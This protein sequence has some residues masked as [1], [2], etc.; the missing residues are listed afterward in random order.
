MKNLKTG[1]MHRALGYA[2]SILVTMFAALLGRHLVSA[3]PAELHPWLESAVPVSIPLQ[4]VD[5]LMDEEQNTFPSEADGASIAE[6]QMD[7]NGARESRGMHATLQVHILLAN[8]KGASD[9]LVLFKLPR[10]CYADIDELSQ[11]HRGFNW[12]R[13]D[14]HAA[15]T[16][17]NPELLAEQAPAEIIGVAFRGLLEGSLEESPSSIFRFSL[18]IHL[19]YHAAKPG[20]GFAR[21]NV[22][23]PLVYVSHTKTDEEE[24]QECSRTAR[25]HGYARVITGDEAEHHRPLSL[26]YRVASTSVT[27]EF[28]SSE[29]AAV[30]LQVPLGDLQWLPLVRAGNYITLGFTTIALLSSVIL[31][32]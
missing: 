23:P 10:G 8:V 11:R 27:T 22:P 20:A 29:F 19:L 28:D 25:R 31:F 32:K 1:K 16:S 14:L 3:T 15:K 7:I 2:I 4:L 6:V 18:P 5:L 17:S 21:V 12:T 30:V 24:D 9:L 26:H 13:V